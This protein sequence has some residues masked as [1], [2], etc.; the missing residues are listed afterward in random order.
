[1]H[2][3]EQAQIAAR[4]QR[5]LPPWDVSWSPYW[6]EFIA[7]SACTPEPLILRD[8]VADR[9]IDQ[10][11]AAQMAALPSGQAAGGQ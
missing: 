11:R 7:I 5:R 4:L 6:R 3:P 10:M 1:M 9:L 2:D 8:P